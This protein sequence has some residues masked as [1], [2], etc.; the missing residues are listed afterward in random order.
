VADGSEDGIGDI[1]GGFFALLFV[2][3]GLVMPAPYITIR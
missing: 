3:T 1:A 2:R